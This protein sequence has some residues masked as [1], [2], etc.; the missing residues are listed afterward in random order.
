ME[1]W[2]LQYDP[3]NFLNE[4]WLRPAEIPLNMDYWRVSR[5]YNRLNRDD[6]SFIWRAN[7]KPGKRNRG[8]YNIA[9]IRSVEPHSLEDERLINLMWES[10]GPRYDPDERRR[11]EQYPA[12]LIKNQYSTDLQPPLL[13]E[14]L[15]HEGFGDLLIIKMARWGTYPLDPIVGERL[16]TYIRRTR[17]G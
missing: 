1:Y 3:K 5:F 16:L 12:I 10:D 9:T 15:R 8:I 4:N 11:L 6:V 14:E 7:S 2:I 17:R 13:I